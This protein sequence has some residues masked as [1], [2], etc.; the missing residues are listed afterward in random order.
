VLLL[1]TCRPRFDILYFC[2]LRALKFHCVAPPSLT[3]RLHTCSI[4]GKA[5]AGCGLRPFQTLYSCRSHTGGHSHKKA[6]NQMEFA[7]SVTPHSSCIG[8]MEQFTD[9]DPWTVH[10]RDYT[11]YHSASPSQ[12][13]PA[14]PFNSLRLQS[15]GTA[16]HQAV[17]TARCCQS[18]GLAACRVGG[19]LAHTEISKSGLCWTFSRPSASHSGAPRFGV[20]LVG[21]P[22]LER[23]HSVCSQAMWKEEQLDIMI[24]HQEA[25]HLL[26]NE[27]RHT[28]TG[29]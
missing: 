3:G 26:L 10:V 9:M 1:E 6:T 14:S 28:E 18:S 25:S 4:Y 29:C 13:A 11:S 17:C 7:A 16:L 22:Q 27:H 5:E 12:Q 24:M 15:P 19:H 23:N 21:P 20:E 8:V 2:G